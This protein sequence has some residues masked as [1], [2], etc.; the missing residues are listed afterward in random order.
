MEKD[1]GGLTGPLFRG[2]WLRPGRHGLSP[3]AV[4][5]PGQ[6]PS[7]QRANQVLNQFFALQAKQVGY[8]LWWAFFPHTRHFVI[9][10]H[11]LQHGKSMLWVYLQ[12]R[13]QTLVS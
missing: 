9:P 7:F 12:Q 8:F 1:K 11:H 10:A 6:L 4:P 5:D 3:V 13:S 2:R